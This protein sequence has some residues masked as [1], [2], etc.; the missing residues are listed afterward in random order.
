[1]SVRS[2]N[3]R[4]TKPESLLRSPRTG[5]GLS[6]PTSSLAGV[7]GCL[8]TAGLRQLKKRNPREEGGAGGG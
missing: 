6:D 1:M 5:P 4:K 7:P 8:A 3:I 2:R